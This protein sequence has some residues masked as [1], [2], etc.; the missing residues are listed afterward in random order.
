MCDSRALRTLSGPAPQAGNP[1]RH[2][3]LQAEKDA[4]LGSA[5]CCPCLEIPNT[6]IFELG[7]VTG[8]MG[9]WRRGT[10]RGDTREAVC[11]GPLQPVHLQARAPGSTEENP[12]Q[13][14][15][16]ACGARTV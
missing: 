13:S 1:G 5:F 10:S 16:Q 11:A 4:L 15:P 3:E 8:S 6:F 12:Q 14:V 2:P 9:Q 7:F